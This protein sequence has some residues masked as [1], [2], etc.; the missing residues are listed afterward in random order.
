MSPFLRKKEVVDINNKINFIYECLVGVK[1]EILFSSKDNKLIKY[2]QYILRDISVSILAAALVIIFTWKV[3]IDMKQIEL[4]NAK[5]SIVWESRMKATK[6]NMEALSKLSNFIEYDLKKSM[7]R[8]LD[9]GQLLSD[10]R[11]NSLNMYMFDEYMKL[12]KKTMVIVKSNSVFLSDSVSKSTDEF[13]TSMEGLVEFNFIVNFNP[14]NLFPIKISNS[15]KNKYIY[16]DKAYQMLSDMS[17][18]FRK[19]F[20]MKYD[21]LKNKYRESLSVQ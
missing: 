21:F 8:D 3:D 15:D 13:L 18:K 5:S 1:H 20:S 4:H 14:N 12:H 19:E 9:N 10:F 7:Y 6:E 2:F 16:P 11:K 17:D